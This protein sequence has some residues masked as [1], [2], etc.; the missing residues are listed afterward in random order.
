[1]PKP[2]LAQRLVAL[3]SAPDRAVSIVGDLV[4]ESRSHGAGWYSLQVLGTS[5]ALCL[6][7]VR[8]DPWRSLRLVFLGLV[9][10]CAALVAMMI[11][12][13]L[14]WY[15]WQLAF[16]TPG[17]WLR[18]G[19]IDLGSNLLTGMIMARWASTERMNGVVPLVVLWL[20]IWIASPLLAWI[21]GY[22]G[23]G[24]FVFVFSRWWYWALQTLLTVPLFYLFPLVLGGLLAEPRAGVATTAAIR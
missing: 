23:P 5:L 2:A 3:F 4:E 21:W 6:S 7:S 8:S 14:P 19:L 1:M 18:V 10:W 15:P 11:M 22:A 9:V 17:F 16:R 12:T 13:G 20:G 24:L